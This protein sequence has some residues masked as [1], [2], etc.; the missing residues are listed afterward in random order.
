MTSRWDLQTWQVHPEPPEQHAP[1]AARWAR[2]LYTALRL[3]VYLIISDSLLLMIMVI[4]VRGGWRPQGWAWPT[5]WAVFG[6]AVISLFS[7]AW[8]HRVLRHYSGVPIC[9]TLEDVVPDSVQA[10]T[11]IRDDLLPHFKPKYRRQVLRLLRRGLREILRHC[12][13]A[14]QAERCNWQWLINYHHR[15]AAG[16]TASLCGLA[17]SLAKTVLEADDQAR[18]ASTSDSAEH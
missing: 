6:A 7:L 16:I 17:A 3:I 4:A 15:K 9:A 1:V 10:A 14:R 8:G 5:C 12:E 11:D 13:L 2:R 18:I